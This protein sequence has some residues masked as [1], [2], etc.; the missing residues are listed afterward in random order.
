MPTP[1]PPPPLQNLIGLLYCRMFGPPGEQS[2][3]LRGEGRQGYIQEK[4]QNPT[5]N[6]GK[7]LLNL[8]VDNLLFSYLHIV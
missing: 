5:T 3:L 8:S 1:P 2:L 6:R 7:K 4:G